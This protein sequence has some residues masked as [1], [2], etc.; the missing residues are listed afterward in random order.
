MNKKL[1]DKLKEVLKKEESF[2][3]SES[4][5]INYVAVKDSSDK[6]DEKLI[7]LL[8]ENKDL[9]EKFFT[10]IK[11]VY[12]FNINDF[13]FFLDENKIFNSYTKYTNR[14]GL[15][16]GDKFLQ[17][18]SDVVLDFPF[19]DCVLEGGQ[20]NEELKDTYFEYEEEKKKTVDGE[21]ITEPAGYKEKQAKRKEV[22]FNQVLAQDE[23]DRLFDKK[24]LVNWKRF[25]KDN[26]KDGDKLSDIK[27]DENG[28]I[29]DNLIIKGN[30]LL[31]LHSLKSE[32]AGKVKLIYIDPPYNTGGSNNT[33]S[34]NNRFNHSS[35]LTFMK[36]R[37]EVAKDFLTDD[38]VIEIAIDEN[39]Q[40]YLGVLIDEIFDGYEKHCITIEHNPRGVQGDNF[41]YTSEFVYFVFKEGLKL[42]NKV[43]REKAIEEEFK[44]HG[45]DSQRSDAKN[46]FYPIL[47]KNNKIVG[48]G[49]VSE[50]SYHPSKNVLRDNEIIEVYPIDAKGVE[51]KWVFARHTV[52]DIKHKLYV[53]DK[54]NGEIDIYRTKDEMTPRTVWKDKRYD[55]S[56]FGSKIVNKIIDGKTV[57]FPKSLYALIDCLSIVVSQDKGAIVMD[58]FSGSGTTAQALLE[59]NK[60]D[61]GNRRFILIEQLND[62]VEVA[63]QRL[64]NEIDEKN[65]IDDS[66]IYFELAKH[67][68]TA[69]EK[70]LSCKNLAELTDLFDDLYN[71]YFLNYNLRIKEF[72]EKVLKEEEFQ[73]LDLNEQKK[74][75]LTMLDLNQ[76]YVQESEMGDK[77]FG[78][79][80]EDQKLTK[81]FYKSS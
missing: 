55:A 4:G 48:F 58:F 40:A 5:E 19:K 12:V 44:D 17:N 1:K 34:Y 20:S 27:R 72:K 70:I 64:K 23:I 29:K 35:W 65:E 50:D 24:A 8:V 54:K 26:K 15:F 32:F 80:E 10:K 68:E 41:S 46:C 73:N 52:E 6:I 13:K 36:N 11:D 3:D 67:N 49:D 45:G 18:E 71:K 25:S 43:P 69:K 14:I 7:S 42:I 62:H 9:K 51:R 63:K 56:T 78:I 74:I 47:V 57:S 60:Q 61:A 37:L 79:S 2:L 75:F 28:T 81:E 39:E 76:M 16:N 53:Q 38:G 30:N 33:F 21:K 66:F 31:A 22:F 77:K 59:I